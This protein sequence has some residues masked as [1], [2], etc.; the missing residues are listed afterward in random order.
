MPAF[1]WV[2]PITPFKV[3]F[4]DTPGFANTRDTQQDKLH[5]ET[6]A[7][8]IKEHIDSITAVLVLANGTVPRGTGGLH[9]A[10]SILSAIVP[11]TFPRNVALVFTHIANPLSWNFCQDT[12][13]EHFK[14][15]P[16][17][18]IDNPVALQKRYLKLKDDPKLKNVDIARMRKEVK[19]GEQGALEMLVDLFDWLD[20][21]ERQPTTEVVSLY[22]TFQNIKAKFIGALAHMAHESLASPDSA[23]NYPQSIPTRARRN[24]VQT[25]LSQSPPPLTLNA[26]PPPQPSMQ[27]LPAPVLEM[28]Q[29]LLSDL[30]KPDNPKDFSVTKFSKKLIEWVGLDAVRI[31]NNHQVAY[32][33]VDQCREAYERINDIVDEIEQSTDDEIKLSKFLK[34]M[35]AVSALEEY[36]PDFPFHIA[37]SLALIQ[38]LLQTPVHL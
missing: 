20:S 10:L 25:S 31:R 28:P 37:V 13:P 36:V 16:Q 30:I 6:F 5:K 38:I 34:Y 18:K 19:A 26:Q 24:D 7:T 12:L 3:R 23:R 32:H 11:N 1:T 33:I 14:D 4:L 27:S 21:L 8:Q 35:D 15:V 17:F 2:V 22:Q 9:Y 29:E